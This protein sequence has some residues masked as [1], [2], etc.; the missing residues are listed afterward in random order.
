MYKYGLAKAIKN[1][2]CCDYEVILPF[3]VKE[4]ADGQTRWTIPSELELPPG[5]ESTLA[6]KALFLLGGMLHRGRRRCIAYMADRAECDAFARMLGIVAE[7]YLAVDLWVDK[8]DCEVGREDRERLYGEF[9]AD[10][11][12]DDGGGGR[13][14]LPAC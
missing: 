10:D 8:I 2:Y 4:G 7:D 13:V 12:D 14:T 5:E 9:Q 11:D 3:I 6:A 1:R